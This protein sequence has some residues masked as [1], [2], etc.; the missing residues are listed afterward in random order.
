MGRSN[1]RP[2]K[3]TDG[4]H[5]ECA[6]HKRIHIRHKKYLLRLTYRYQAP[7]QMAADGDDRNLL[8]TILKVTAKS[9]PSCR[10]QQLQNP[11]HFIFGIVEM[12]AKSQIM[13]P[14]PILAWSTT[15][16]HSSQTVSH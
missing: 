15:H 8:Q 2:R 1:I 6:S 4:C 12:R 9:Q 5:Q 13:I 14:L 7:V 3:N 11:V 16:S 10:L